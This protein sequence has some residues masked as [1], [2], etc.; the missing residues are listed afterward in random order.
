MAFFTVS[1]CA[2]QKEPLRCEEPCSRTL[3]AY[4]R[5]SYQF[6]EDL[7]KSPFMIEHAGRS[8]AVTGLDTLGT[9]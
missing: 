9:V 1:F 3:V 8:R 5:E 6:F 4:L 2:L 7:L